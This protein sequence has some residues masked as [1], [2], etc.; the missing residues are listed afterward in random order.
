MQS[1]LADLCERRGSGRSALALSRRISYFTSNCTAGPASSGTQAMIKTIW[2]IGASVRALAETLVAA[3]YEVVA[4]DLFCDVDLRAIADTH[5]LDDFPRDALSHELAIEADAWIYA[6]GLENFPELIELLS[7]RRPLLGNSAATLRL[8]RD[9]A[10]F[11]AFLAE[12][13]FRMPE[14][15]WDPQVEANGW[16]RKSKHSSGGMSVQKH[17]SCVPIAPHEYMQKFVDGTCYGATFLADQHSCRL[18]GVAQAIDMRD[19]THAPGFQYSGS[20]GPIN[21]PA[22]IYTELEQLGEVLRRWSGLLGWFG[23]DFIV[24]HSSRIWVLEVNPRYTASIDVFGIG[25]GIELAKK[26]VAVCS[27]ETIS[28]E[29]IQLP[30]E[31]TTKAILYATRSSKIELRPLEKLLDADAWPV[32][33]ADIPNAGTIVRKGQPILTLLASG[34]HGEEQLRDCADRV[35]ALLAQS[36]AI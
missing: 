8:V 10:K 18:V 11:S 25:A 26:H 1:T 32:R 6:G 35:Y 30:T 28:G 33:L 2:V 19:V 20:V 15:R 13:G 7:R 27:G 3:G 5:R 17:D 22:P 23:I 21:L 4:S 24:D 14:N 36:E 34:T 9:F 12:Y 29:R 31:R 16:L